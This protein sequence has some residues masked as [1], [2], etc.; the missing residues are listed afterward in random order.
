MDRGAAVGGDELTMR[1]LLDTSVI[2]D[3]VHGHG[4]ATW[5]LGR[6]LDAQGELLTCDV[7]IGEALVNGADDQ[8]EAVSLVLGSL[9]YVPTSARVAADA[10]ALR[11][12]RRRSGA[13]L[14]LADA[15]LAAVA[16]GAGATLVTRGR[17]V[18]G[19]IPGL[20]ILTY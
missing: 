13:S 1:Y 17:P 14:G 9:E 10:A 18:L 20:R 16:K 12:D 19:S 8:R 3:H 11:T 7:V 2:L 15:L 5:L 6:L 4:P